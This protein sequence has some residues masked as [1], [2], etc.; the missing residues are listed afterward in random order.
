MKNYF[1]LPSFK[2]SMLE[3]AGRTLAE[4]VE[5]GFTLKNYICLNISRAFLE[6]K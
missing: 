4:V 6:N 3:H 5:F 2:A 1:Q